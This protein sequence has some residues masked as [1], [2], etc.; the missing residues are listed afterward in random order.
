MERW[1]AL[2]VVVPVAVLAACSSDEEGPEAEIVVDTLPNGAIHVQNPAAG[3]WEEGEEWTMEEA[4][5]IGTLDGDPE[6]MFQQVSMLAP[7]SR[8]WI[9][10]LD[11]QADEIR[12]FDETGQHVRTLGGSG[13]GP[14]ELGTPI[15]VALDP[16]DRVWAAD[17][18]NGRYTVWD[19]DGEVVTTRN[20][21]VPLWPYAWTAGFDGDR[22][23]EHTRL[24][25]GPEDEVPG[26][27]RVSALDDEPVDSLPTP[28]VD[29]E[30]ESYEVSDDQGAMFVA[31]PYHPGVQRAVDRTGELWF[32][33]S[34]AYRLYQ[35]SLDGDTLRIVEREHEPVPVDEEEVREFAESEQ[36]EQLEARG[37]DVDLDRIP[38]V[39]PAFEQVIVSDDGHLWVRTALP[40]GQERTRFDVFDPEG[41]YLGAVRAPEDLS[42]SPR[43]A[44][45]DG[46]LWAQVVDDLDVPYVVGYRIEGRDE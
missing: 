26:F 28:R 42:S 33:R 43:P 27:L 19:Q 13:E 24:D 38:D 6:E 30:P 12:V 2:T 3:L 37:G 32:G 10:V 17:M 1:V 25:G 36:A 41:R 16:D 46:F 9:H 45:R 11:R 44:I 5:R 4:V 39:K 22:L 14:G 35:A 40:Y 20:R 29:H 21:P 18:G 15:G 7:D 34:D 23:L 8:G 31:V